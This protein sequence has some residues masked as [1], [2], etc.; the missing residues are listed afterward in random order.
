MKLYTETIQGDLILI[1]TNIPTRPPCPVIA[2]SAKPAASWLIR[3]VLWL[4]ACFAPLVAHW[5]SPA[6]AANKARFA[7]LTIVAMAMA[8]AIIEMLA[9]I[10]VERALG[11]MT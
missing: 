11:V 4:V 2:R 8:M 10:H 3:L 7:V 6:W 1:K 9:E 5:P